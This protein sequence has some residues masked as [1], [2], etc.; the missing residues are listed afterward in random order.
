M[1][2]E[3]K[4]ILWVH[5]N[6]YYEVSPETHGTHEA[7]KGYSWDSTNNILEAITR[8]DSGNYRGTFISSLSLDCPTPDTTGKN[9]IEKLELTPSTTKLRYGIGLSLARYAFNQNLPVLVRPHNN[10]EAKRATNIQGLEILE[11]D[12]ITTHHEYEIVLARRFKEVFR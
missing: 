3:T 8:I 6:R 5:G 4:K 1:E 7:F 9:A 12:P 2:I 11:Y 10:E